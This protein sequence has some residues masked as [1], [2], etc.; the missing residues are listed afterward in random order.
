MAGSL[1]GF[2]SLISIP[3]IG[4]HY[5]L[6]PEEKQK[7]GITDNLIRWNPYCENSAL[8]VFQ[9]SEANLMMR[10][11]RKCEYYCRLSIGLEDKLDLIEDLSQ[12]LTSAFSGEELSERAT[13]RLSQPVFSVE[14]VEN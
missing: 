9:S 13:H 7:W 11:V 5:T 14:N 8:D 3:T 2:E 12:A 6:T 4:S 10:L 1:G